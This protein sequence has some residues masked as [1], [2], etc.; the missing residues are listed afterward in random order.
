MGVKRFT[1]LLVED[2]PGDARL[3]KESLCEVAGDHFDVETADRLANAVERLRG[4]DID[5]VLL[6]LALPDSHGRDTFE[7]AKSA[8]PEVPII[9]LTGLGDEALAVGMVQEGA[10][11]YLVKVDLSGNVLSRAIRYAIERGNTEQQIRRLNIELEQKVRARTA[12]LEMANQELEAF[13]YSVSHDLRAPIRHINGFAGVLLDS[14]DQFDAERRDCVQGIYR[15]GLRMAAMTEDLLKLAR[16]GK[17]PLDLRTTSLRSLVE[18]VVRELTAEIGV[19]Q[20]EWQIGKL[21]AVDCD[22]GLI[23]QAF[24]NLID[25]AIKYTKR[26]EIA[27]IEIGQSTVA[28]ALTI[29][30]RDNGEGFDMKHADRLFAPFQRLHHANDF[31]GTGVGL[32]TVRRIIDKHGGRIWVE[33]EMGKGTQVF[34]TL[35][36][37]TSGLPAGVAAG[38]AATF[39]AVS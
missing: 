7:R 20:I 2:N 29:F 11:D 1:I 12:E 25:N 32:S 14:L 26:K 22:P 6:D 9:V 33:S 36:R 35:A 34:F 38:S 24:A 10:Q 28:D 19:R 17:Q 15:A 37:E 5:A 16:I 3:I 8:A 31:E 18:V 39:S 13:T 23:K 30:V 4:G 27:Q 21:P